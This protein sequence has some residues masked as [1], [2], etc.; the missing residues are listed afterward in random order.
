MSL[1]SF[2]RRCVECCLVWG[3]VVS[4][5]A[6]AACPSRHP[7][8]ACAPEAGASAAEDVV[9]YS[10]HPLPVGAADV[11]VVFIGGLGDEISGIVAEL[12][13]RAP[14]LLLP[15]ETRELRAYYHWHAGTPERTLKAASQAIAEDMAAFRHRNPGA[16]VVLIGHSLGASTALRAALLLKPSS[17]RVYLLT[18]DPVDRTMRP[19]R[20]EAVAWWGNGYV[21]HSASRRDFIAVWG[22]RWGDC[23]GADR[24]LCFDGRRRDEEG[25]PY[26]HDNAAALLLSRGGRTSSLL[27]ELRQARQRRVCFSGCGREGEA[28]STEKPPPGAVPGRGQIGKS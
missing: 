5:T 10:Q 1:S 16:D 4:A 15:G 11:G 3:T 6:G 25:H 13:R 23:P 8:S 19:S 21:A 9:R 12:Q 26:I 7:Q 18:L 17:G 20:P 2:F 27:E 28:K 22:G 24:N 14:S